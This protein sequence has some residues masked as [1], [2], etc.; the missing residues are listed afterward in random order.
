MPW[1]KE[2]YERTVTVYKELLKDFMCDS[3]KDIDLVTKEW[4]VRTEILKHDFTK[5]QLV[6]LSFIITLSFMFGKENALIPKLQD[7]E[8]AGISKKKIKEEISKLEA[9]NV[10]KWNSDDNTFTILEPRLWNAPYNAGYNDNRSRE[11]F[12][13]NL[14]HAGVDIDPIIEKLKQMRY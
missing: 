12:L 11:L 10:I 5:R 1:A 7:F 2:T 3:K 4:L 8:I 6:I 9:M 14:K 13:L